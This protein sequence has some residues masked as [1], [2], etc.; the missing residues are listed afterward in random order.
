MGRASY[1]PYPKHV[2]FL[3][4]DNPIMVEKIDRLFSH[5]QKVDSK[6]RAP[7]G[8]VQFPTSFNGGQS[9][10]DSPLY[11]ME[12]A[13]IWKVLPG[14]YMADKGFKIH[15]M[16]HR[17]SAGLYK[18]PHRRRGFAQLTDDEV[19]STMKVANMR[20]HVERDMRRA[21]EFH[22]LNKT[23]PIPHIDMASVEAFNAFMLGNFQPP[24]IGNDFFDQ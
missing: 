2:N 11:S 5:L 4:R 9:D 24:L 7:G 12:Q 14:D 18:P 23:I 22:L 6:N 16:L 8:A 19:R 15:D 1:N 20:I 21:R 3:A 10:S 17:W 13:R